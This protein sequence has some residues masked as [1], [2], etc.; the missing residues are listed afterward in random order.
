MCCVGA[1]RQQRCKGTVQRKQDS[2]AFCLGNI[3]R[4]R[5][6]IY[7]TLNKGHYLLKHLV[8]TLPSLASQI[9]IYPSLLSLGVSQQNV[10]GRTLQEQ[11][12]EECHGALVGFIRQLRKSAS[13]NLPGTRSIQLSTQLKKKKQSLVLQC[14]W[15]YVLSPMSE[16]MP[17]S[18]PGKFPAGLCRTSTACVE[19]SWLPSAPSALSTREK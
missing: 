1:V 9:A 6:L 4:V 13:F 3:P 15:V 11:G 12:R 7:Y 5:L 17:Q 14:P 8:N 18:W 2:K 19:L 10:H 16:G